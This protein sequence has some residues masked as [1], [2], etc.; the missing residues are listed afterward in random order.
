MRKLEA[1]VALLFLVNACGEGRKVSIQNITQEEFVKLNTTEIQL[2]DVRT[3]EEVN[4]GTI[5]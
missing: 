5:E 4:K 3:P 2:L 1:I